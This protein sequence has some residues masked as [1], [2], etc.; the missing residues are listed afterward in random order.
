[1]E[2]KHL[3]ALINGVQ[4]E[5][6]SKLTQGKMILKEAKRYRRVEYL[7]I[8][9]LA[10]G[11]TV[12]PVYPSGSG[13]HRHYVDRTAEVVTILDLLGVAYV[14]DNDAP[15]QGRTGK[16]INVPDNDARAWLSRLVDNA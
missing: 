10:R 8:A 7:L 2:K 5:K 13:R 3:D 15:R 4:K 14:T 16:T 1:M 12:R 9:D 11:A 6:F